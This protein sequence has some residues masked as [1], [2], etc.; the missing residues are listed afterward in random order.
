MIVNC[1]TLHFTLSQL[2]LVWPMLFYLPSGLVVGYLRVATADQVV[3]VHISVG[4]RTRYTFIFSRTTYQG[5][6]L[7]V[8]GRE[9]VVAIFV[10]V[11]A[12][13]VE[14]ICV[15]HHTPV[16]EA[17]NRHV[18]ERAFSFDIP[19]DSSLFT[20]DP[21]AGSAIEFCHSVIYV[22][23]VVFRAASLRKLRSCCWNRAKREYDSHRSEHRFHS[24]TPFLATVE[25]A[26]LGTDIR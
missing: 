13:P 12:A 18:V 5:S 22:V 11:N 3:N 4:N 6:G 10:G 24:G 7:V 26:I 9:Y 8:E 25:L 21:R 1:W 17:A 23:S 15:S 19:G 16:I 14:V 2:S 20:D